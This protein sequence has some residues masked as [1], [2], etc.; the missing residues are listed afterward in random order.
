MERTK[1]RTETAGQDIPHKHSPEA[2]RVEFRLG[3]IFHEM[4]SNLC[5]QRSINV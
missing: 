3:G 1:R 2:G 5:H 4:L